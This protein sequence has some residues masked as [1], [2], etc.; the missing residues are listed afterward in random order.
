MKQQDWA[1]V[2]KNFPLHF[3]DHTTKSRAVILSPAHL[4]QTLEMDWHSDCSADSLEYT[5][6][7]WNGTPMRIDI[8]DQMIGTLAPNGDEMEPAFTTWMDQY[9]YAVL[10]YSAAVES[11]KIWD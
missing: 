1:S 4:V 9:E 10:H 6:T 8:G 2:R 5:I 7:A 11:W 3:F